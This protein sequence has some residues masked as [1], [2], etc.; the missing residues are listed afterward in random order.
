MK[1][2]LNTPDGVCAHIL[3]NLPELLEGRCHCEGNELIFPEWGARLT[4]VCEQV[5]DGFCVLGMYLYSQR[6]GKVLYECSA[7]MGKDTETAVGMALGQYVFSFLQGLGVMESGEDPHPVNSMLGDNI[8]RYNAYLSDITGIGN[9]PQVQPD[10]YWNALKDGIVKRLGN[11]RLCYVKVFTSKMDDNITCE[12]RVNDVVSAELSGI[13]TDM[14]RKWDNK[15]YASHKQFFF[16][17]QN[18]SDYIPY[19]YEKG[20]FADKVK[21]AVTLFHQNYGKDD[22]FDRI[23]ELAARETGDETLAW[24]CCYFLPEICTEHAFSDISYAETI[25]LCYPDGTKRTVYKAQLRDYNR[26]RDTLFEMFDD[27]VFGDNANDIYRE[28]IGA[29]ASYNCI[30]QMKEKGSDLKNVCMT[31]I[32]YNVPQSFELR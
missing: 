26:L 11:E 23:E 30:A 14:V 5:R 21:K 27:G 18:D 13:L 12:C 10:D 32:L 9:A 22:F 4:P 3:K 25:E 20:E 24:E 28:F 8:H 15:E 17:R 1:Q 2:A 31:A 16:I 6:F 7:G 29:S 19:P